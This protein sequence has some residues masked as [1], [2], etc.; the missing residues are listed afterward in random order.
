[1][2]GAGAGAEAES[3]DAL[4]AGPIVDGGPATEAPPDGLRVDDLARAAGTTVRNVRAYQDRGLLSPPRREGRIA[5]YGAEHVDRLRL[6]GSMLDRGFTLASIGALL[7]GW[8]R[9][10]DLGELLGLGAQL[11]GTEADEA[12]DEGPIVEVAAR[13]GLPL[14]DAE[15]IRRALA[16]GLVE[17]HGD[18]LRVPSPRLLRAGLELRAAGVPSEVLFDELRRLR[19]D[20]EAMADRFV[21][22]VVANVLEPHFVDG[23]PPPAKVPDLAAVVARIRP[24]ATTVVAAEL[25]RALQAR[26]EAELGARVA[27]LLG[28]AAPAAP[29]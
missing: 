23:V 1:M 21:P 9:G 2:S 12:P 11:V 13:Y 26:A 19:A 16:F 14:D 5:W 6:I 18:R 15:E 4:A 29:T 20:A 22:M 17:V 24:L 3:G 10:L 7:D 8:T 25:A 27:E 28:R